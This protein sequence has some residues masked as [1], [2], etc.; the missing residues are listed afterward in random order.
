[1]NWPIIIRIP[2]LPQTTT[3]LALGFLVGC[4]LFIPASKTATYWSDWLD[5]V[6]LHG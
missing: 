2:P 4:L 3:L 6:A 1:M 5:W